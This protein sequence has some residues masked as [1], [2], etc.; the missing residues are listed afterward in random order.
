MRDS[1]QTDAQHRCLAQMIAFLG[2]GGIA[3]RPA[4]PPAWQGS[5][6]Q[7]SVEGHRG[8]LPFVLIM[9]VK[10]KKSA[11]A[12]SIAFLEVLLCSLGATCIPPFH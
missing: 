9:S 11:F 7:L 5:S 6:C 2:H 12:M 4:S 3:H 10:K 1:D 8:L